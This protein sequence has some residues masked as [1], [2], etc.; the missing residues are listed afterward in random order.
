MDQLPLPEPIETPLWHP[1]AETGETAVSSGPADSAARRVRP[2]AGAPG[3]ICLFGEHQDYHGL[4]VVAAAISLHMR[5]EAEE[6]PDGLLTIELPDIGES[7]V[8]D[9]NATQEYQ[10]ARDYLR[11]S[12]AV[13]QRRGYGWPRGYRVRITGT[14]PIRAG[15]SSSSAMVV[16]WLQFLMAISDRPVAVDA[17]ELARLGHLA[18]VV[19]FGEPGGMMDH[20][21]AAMGGLLCITTVAPYSAER[22]SAPIDGI[23]LG[24]SLEP[25]ATI[26]TLAR[27]RSEV[28]EG[29]R[30]MR[31]KLPDFDLA[32]TSLDEAEEHLGSMPAGPARRLRANLVN[33]DLTRA[34]LADLRRGD[35]SRLG[36]LLLAH[37]EQLRDGLDLSTPKVERMLAAAVGA[38]ALG[39]KINGS[40]GGGC[41]YA[42]AP[43]KTEAVAD[44]IRGVGGA[45]I[46]VS[47]APGAWSE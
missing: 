20:F 43:G 26:E 17:E 5:A 8:I 15:V 40:G 22:L 10:S 41:M 11:S 44:A 1:S 35:V 25:K 45:P 16:M 13:L 32:R 9:P 12:V 38:G 36:P 47:V 27:V 39:G 3:R 14:I 18:E 33:R 42:Y 21:C 30:L 46:I 29:M 37:H 2:E 7:L 23:V 31:E 24:D 4:P 34:A 28:G 6:A 19:E